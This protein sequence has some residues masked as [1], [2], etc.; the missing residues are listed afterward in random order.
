MNSENLETKIAC[1]NGLF[2]L[3]GAPIEY[4]RILYKKI[5]EKIG[6]YERYLIS[7]KCGVSEIRDIIHNVSMK[8]NRVKKV[9]LI[10][11]ANSLNLI[12]MNLLLKAT[13]ESSEKILFIC[14]SNNLEFAIPTFLS[15]SKI[16]DCGSFFDYSIAKEASD[17]VEVK[18]I[19]ELSDLLI[20]RSLLSYS[21]ISINNISYILDKVVETVL[22][23]IVEHLSI[24]TAQW[25]M[26]YIC[27]VYKAF[28][29]KI[30]VVEH[31]I[32]KETVFRCKNVIFNPAFFTNE[33][34][35]EF[36]EDKWIKFLTMT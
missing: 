33:L 20:E 16:I 28:Q 12:K 30:S 27:S 36:K 8:T 35:K 21:E 3:H 5:L 10:E 11:D 25:S 17:G 6:V 32:V 26:C 4:L 15:R 7:S 1:S 18:S 29:Y 2:V 13:E 19:Q 24:V 14:I 31:D 22:E 34:V 23:K 9:I